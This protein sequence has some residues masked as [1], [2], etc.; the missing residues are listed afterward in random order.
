MPHG[1]IIAPDLDA[2][3][4]EDYCLKL[5]DFVGISRGLSFQE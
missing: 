1:R 5:V 4:A 2:T 3:Q